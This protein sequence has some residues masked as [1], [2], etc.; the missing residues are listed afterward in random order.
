MT[1]GAAVRVL[2]VEHENVAPAAWVGRWLVDAG[3]ELDVR[4]PYL[5]QA[6]PADLA[7]H[8]ALLVL[9]GEMGA[10]D[11]HVPWIV[12]T[13]ELIARAAVEGVPTLGICLG[14][15]LCTVALGGAVARNPQ[16][17]QM[18]VVDV[19]WA[20]GAS[21]DPLLGAV[22][23]AALAVHWNSDVVTEVPEGARVLARAPGGEV[24]AVRLAPSVW[25]VQ[26][27]PEVDEQIVA[28]W[29]PVSREVHGDGPVD[30]ALARVAA[31]RDELHASWRPLAGALVA[32]AAA[33][34]H[35]EPQMETV[36]DA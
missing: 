32:L 12:P 28:S 33:R 6:L 34:G 1:A 11:D 16:G 27:H 30:E 22:V 10:T 3:A 26:L 25:G 15:Q 7:D 9:G 13:K 5:G 31:A 2:V 8:D 14:H 17:Q 19:G 23:D 20:E 29:A 4:R 24:Q 21:A 36:R 35:T 18:G